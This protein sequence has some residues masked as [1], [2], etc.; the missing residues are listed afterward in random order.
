[1]T[2]RRANPVLLI[3]LRLYLGALFIY[4]GFIKLSEPVENFQAAI[5]QYSLVPYVLTPYLARTMPWMELVGGVFLIAGYLTRWSALLLAAIS[6][7]FCALIGSSFL[8]GSLPPDCGCFGSSGIHLALRE[9]FI[10]DWVNFF[11]GLW[12][13]R[14]RRHSGAVENLFE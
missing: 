13:F 5:Q 4:A 9:V 6:L 14:T 12:L 3:L 10:L 11:L 1:M 2:E 7:S 8:A